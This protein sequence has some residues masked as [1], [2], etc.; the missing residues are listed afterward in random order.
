M[1][2]RLMTVKCCNLD[3]G[4]Q[5]IT[6]CAKRYNKSQNVENRAKPESDA[7]TAATAQVAFDGR[8][9]KIAGALMRCLQGPITYQTN[10]LYSSAAGFKIFAVQ[11]DASP[12]Q[13]ELPT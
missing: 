3:N 7:L 9:W 13:R 10:N 11:T 4:A 1:K 6:G 5:H 12:K 8:L 2:V